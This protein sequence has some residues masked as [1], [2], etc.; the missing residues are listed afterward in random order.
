M[1]ELRKAESHS[2]INFEAMQDNVKKAELE[3]EKMKA[4]K[5]TVQEELDDMRKKGE[6]SKVKE[7]VSKS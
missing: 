1:A 5:E 6:D 3:M 4:A 2:A 7:Y